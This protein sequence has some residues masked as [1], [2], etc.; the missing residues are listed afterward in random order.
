[1][2]RQVFGVPAMRPSTTTTGDRSVP[3][4]APAPPRAGTGRTAALLVLFVAATII[5][6][7][8]PG[9]ALHG[10]GEAAAPG[11]HW[12]TLLRVLLFAAVC[13]QVGEVIA[14]WLARRVPRAPELLPRGWSAA[15]AWGGAVAALG[16]ALIVAAG[17]LVPSRLADMDLADLYRTRDGLLALLE[18]DAFLVAALLARSRRPAAQALPLA[19]IAVAEALR[20]HPATEDGPLLGSA[21]TLVHFTCAALWAG[22]LL[23]VLRMVRLWRALEP[24]AGAELLARYARGAAGLLIALTVTGVCSTLRRMPPGTVLDQLTS[25]AYGRT[26]LAKVL[27][28]AVASALALCAR[29]RLRHAADPLTACT[30]ARFEVLTLGLTVAVTALLTALPVPIRW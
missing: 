2:Q 24:A 20:A 1:M 4:A 6:L 8:G 15:A 9:A 30:P 7:A 22:G 13:V 3:A 26:L 5:S 29:R 23:H 12:V 25:T 18:V 14:P 19:A 10:T 17:N 21:L 28:V 27:L 11:A 16:L